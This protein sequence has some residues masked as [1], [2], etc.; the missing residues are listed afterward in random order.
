MSGD[1]FRA[2]RPVGDFVSVQKG[3]YLIGAKEHAI[4]TKS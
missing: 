1:I 3:L 4:V 2:G